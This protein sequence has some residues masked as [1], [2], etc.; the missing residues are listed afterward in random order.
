VK[1]IVDIKNKWSRAW[2]QAWF[3]CKV[4]LIRSPSP[5]RGKGIYALHSY[6]TELDFVTEPPF[7]CPDGDA[8][9]VAFVKATHTIGGQDVVKYMAYELLPLL[10]SFGLGEVAD[11]ETLLSKLAAPMP[12]FPVAALLEETNDAFQTI[13]ELAVVNIIGRYARREHKACVELVPN[14][15]RVNRVFEHTG[16]L[17]A[18]P[19]AWLWGERGGC[20]EEK[21]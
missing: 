15:G 1:L 21:E 20:K 11:G 3:Y 5:G 18:S 6:M 12:D 9:D 19:G 10:A 17:Q 7:E 2:T 8:G 16:V 4:P 14:E 13:V